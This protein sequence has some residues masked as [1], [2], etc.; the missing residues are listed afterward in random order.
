MGKGWVLAFWFKM[1]GFDGGKCTKREGA[2]QQSSSFAIHTKTSS[3]D[4]H[5]GIVMKSV[6]VN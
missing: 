4:R 3:Q 2:L 5:L 6:A 1:A